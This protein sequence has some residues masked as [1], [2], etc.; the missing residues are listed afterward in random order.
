MFAVSPLEIKGTRPFSYKNISIVIGIKKYTI[1]NR[2]NAV[3]RNNIV[4]LQNS[5]A[6]TLQMVNGIISNYAY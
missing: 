6:Q 1:C 5:I 2:R 4:E 3:F